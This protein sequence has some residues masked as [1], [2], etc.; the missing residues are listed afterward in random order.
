MAIRRPESRHW[1][2]WL[3]NRADL[4]A[5]HWNEGEPCTQ[6]GQTARHSGS[7]PPGK[8]RTMKRLP[9]PLA[10]IAA[11]APIIALQNPSVPPNKTT[12]D[13]RQSGSPTAGQNP[14][15]TQTTQGAAQTQPDA[16]KAP[17]TAG[18]AA[19]GMPQ[20]S[21]DAARQPSPI[22][23]PDALLLPATLQLQRWDT[24]GTGV[25]GIP[26]VIVGINESRLE[27]AVIAT[28]LDANVVSPEAAARLKLPT[29]DGSVRIDALN[30]AT[31]G[32]QAEI[33][34]LRASTLE[35]SKIPVA[36]ADV[37]KMISDHPHPE[38]PG[39]WLGAPFLT[40]FQLTLDPT[41]RTI[42][43]DKATAK[44]VRPKR[45]SVSKLEMRNGR[46]YVQM[47]IPG[48]KPFWAL[49]DTSCPATLIPGDVIEKLK[50]KPLRIEQFTSP[51]A[52]SGKGA[53]VI[54]PKLSVGKAE[55]L[56]ARV[57]YLT[58][59]SGKG[60]DRTFAVVG[61][62]FLGQFKMTLDFLH[63]QVAL[64]P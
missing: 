27:R 30:E 22:K 53:V 45:A 54:L 46:P 51:D 6:P 21:P 26:M 4:G 3:G 29:V 12:G 42:T 48:A 16:T 9:V 41:T 24:L 62:D 7:N 15:S 49:I 60:V 35:L 32:P 58:P 36:V 14:A 37:P 34:T 13:P 57:T 43:L 40:A 5:G 33:T 63:G 17:P 28:G 20:P 25:N 55:W 10:L 64:T 52:K 61:M 50:L 47:S 23:L 44:F 31:A 18:Q 39:T 2:E 11:A 1:P 8:A 59:D 38:A 19:S 56:H